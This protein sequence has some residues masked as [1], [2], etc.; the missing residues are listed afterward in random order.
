MLVSVCQSSASEDVVNPALMQA[1]VKGP[2]GLALRFFFFFSFASV[3]FLRNIQNL[4]N[5]IITPFYFQLFDWT[6]W[7]VNANDW[8][9]ER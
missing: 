6:K 2:G 1:F 7:F 8:E 4:E 3:T 9:S 5:L